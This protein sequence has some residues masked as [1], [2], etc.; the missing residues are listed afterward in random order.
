MRLVGETYGL[1]A[2]PGFPIPGSFTQRVTYWL[3]GGSALRT[4]YRVHVICYRPYVDR[5]ASRRSG[6]CAK[7]PVTIRVRGV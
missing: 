1:E 5:N 7:A 6:A 2:A 3:S 4:S